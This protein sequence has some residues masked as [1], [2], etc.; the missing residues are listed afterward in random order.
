MESYFPQEYSNELAREGILEII[1]SG[2]SEILEFK[3]TICTNLLTKEVD[4]RM[5]KAVLKSMVA[6]MNTSGGILLIGVTDSGEICGVDEEQFDSKDKMYQHLSH[7]ISSKIGD[8]FSPYITL[9]LI[10]M[11][12]GKSVVRADC[13]KC[14][15]PVF[16]KEGKN[17]E[18][19]VRSGPS[20]I[21]LSGSN[22]VNY[23][24]NKSSRQKQ[25]IVNEAKMREY[26]D[27][28]D[29]SP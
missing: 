16:L 28:M 23:I 15:K 17:E 13:E 12:D 25:G 24:T 3:S 19:Y 4:K 9:R 1:K 10:E 8:E 2:E 26:M 11:G 6:F 27:S 20:S 5:E 29:K 14:K 21:I 18:F 7:L 22:L